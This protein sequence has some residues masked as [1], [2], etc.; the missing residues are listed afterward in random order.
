QATATPAIPD[1]LW[2]AYHQWQG[3]SRSNTLLLS[4]YGSDRAFPA[5][6][7]RVSVHVC[8]HALSLDRIKNYL[9]FRGEAK[10]SKRLL[11]HMFWSRPCPDHYYEYVC[12]AGQ[13]SHGRA[14]QYRRR[15]NDDEIK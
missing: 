6:C 5:I 14:W 9:R 10:H 11:N 2:A 15:I 13:N 7:H 4:C 8:R 1:L 3:F 12:K